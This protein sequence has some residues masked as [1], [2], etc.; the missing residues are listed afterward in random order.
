MTGE[1]KE[2]LDRAL[3]LPTEG[4]AALAG[5]LIE[6]LDGTVD[7]DAEELWAK[8]IAKRVAELDQGSVTAVPWIDVRQRLLGQ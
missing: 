6:S 2:I 1:T 3:R 7:P 4:R 5:S 8:V